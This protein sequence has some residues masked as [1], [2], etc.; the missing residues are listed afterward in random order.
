MNQTSPTPDAN[1]RWQ[2]V[3]AVLATIGLAPELVTG[4]LAGT[5]AA[6]G[7]VAFGQSLHSLR[8][9]AETID[10][11]GL[12]IADIRDACARVGTV[13]AEEAEDDRVIIAVA[14]RSGWLQLNPATLIVGIAAESI[15]VTVFAK[16]GLID[17]KTAAGALKRFLAA[18]P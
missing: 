16:E 17:Q 7:G 12:P 9:A 3:A 5:V 4:V 13:H 14:S 1:P 11:A 8:C 10:R 15:A 18:L 6:A 2:S